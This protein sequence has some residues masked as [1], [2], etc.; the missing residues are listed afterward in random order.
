MT[1]AAQVRRIEVTFPCGRQFVSAHTWVAVAATYPPRRGY[2]LRTVFG[3]DTPD[4]FY[5]LPPTDLTCANAA[6]VA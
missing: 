3:W 6:G 4:G 2:R 5:Y 1:T